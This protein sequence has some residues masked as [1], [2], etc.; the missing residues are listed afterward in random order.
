MRG[1]PKVRSAAPTFPTGKVPPQRQKRRKP[2]VGSEVIRLIRTM[3]PPAGGATFL[4]V[5][6]DGEE[7]ARQ[8]EGLFTKPPLS[9]DSLS[10]KMAIDA[11]QTNPAR[12]PSLCSGRVRAVHAGMSRPD[13]RPP[14]TGDSYLPHGEGAAAAAEEAKAC[15]FAGTCTFVP[16]SLCEGGA[17]PRAAEGEKAG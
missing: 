17:A 2:K 8:G 7:R 3:V 9:L 15:K 5:Q 12:G 4:L 1:K 10:P 13:D 6:K 11:R 16:P 14:Q